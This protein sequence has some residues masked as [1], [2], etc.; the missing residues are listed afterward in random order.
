MQRFLIFALTISFSL[1]FV[2]SSKAQD[3]AFYQKKKVWTTE[4]M[5]L[6]G[7]FDKVKKPRMEDF[8]TQVFHFEPTHQDTTGTCWSFSTISFLESDLYRQHQIKVRLSEMFV[9]YWEYVEKARRFV[10]EKGDSFFGQGSESNSAIARIKQ[11]GIVPRQV[12]DG[13]LPGQER[14]NHTRMFREMKDYLNFIKE[15]GY[16][17]EDIVLATIKQ[18]LNKYMGEPPLSFEYK[19]QTFT[20]V[21]F[22][23]QYCKL[24]PDDYVEFMS[25]IKAPFYTKAEFE[26]PDNWWHSKDYR[27]IPL[28]VFYKTIKQ[29]IKNGYSVAIGGDVSEPGR[30]NEGDIAIIVPW[31]LPQKS[32]NQYS[33]ELRI[34]N[35]T[36][37][38]DHSVHLVGYTHKY[39]HDWF[40]IKDS[41]SGSQKGEYKGYFFFRD[42]FIK[43]KMLS[44]MVHKDAVKDLL[45][46]F[47]DQ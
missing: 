31:D 20:P 19:G 37:T 2:L 39:G 4:R 41:A 36:T 5:V 10:R 29:A 11:Y 40:L 1:I 28:D 9:V 47:D 45:E 23:D 14:Y 25:T 43:L 15:K 21:T 3:K 22:R 17:D 33:R 34:Y 46:K 26:A 24:N 18:I 32:I 30:Y 8:K 16:W 7:N 27:N 44:F 38:D 6:T 13:L 35:R 42:D 12:Y